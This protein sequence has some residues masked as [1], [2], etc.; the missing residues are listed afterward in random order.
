VIR[1]VSIGLLLVAL[2]ACGGSVGSATDRRPVC[3][4]RFA[5]P[6]G[7]A[8]IETF[9]DDYAD[10]VG[11]RLGYRD[12]RQREFHVLVGIPGEIGEGLPP[13]GSLDLREGRIGTLVGEGTVWVVVWNEH[14]VCDP[15]AVIGNGFTR[16]GFE[17]FLGDA[18][19]VERPGS[20]K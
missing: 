2:G 16:S 13:A 15:R 3:E 17:E 12:D 4:V 20:V 5:A 7:F 11:V 14:D 6:V 1:R 19:L 9:E 18:G 8:P 10:H